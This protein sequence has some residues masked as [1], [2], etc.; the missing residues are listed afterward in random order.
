MTLLDAPRVFRTLACALALALA[1]TGC[2]KKNRPQPPEGAASSYTHP[3]T[4]PKPSSV[5]PGKEEKAV[6]RPVE[7]THAGGIT[8]FPSER[9]TRTTTYGSELAQ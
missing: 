6:K 3:Q 7:P 8:T 1:L 4:Y 9:R 2:G 5:L